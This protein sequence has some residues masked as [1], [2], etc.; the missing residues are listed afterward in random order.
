MINEYTDYSFPEL[1]EDEQTYL[2]THKY[3]HEVLKG[4]ITANKWI[5]LAAERHFKDL[6]RSE[7]NDFKYKFSP[8]RAQH[9]I[10]FFKLTTH[11][12]GVLAGQPIRLM[13]W[14]MF[15]IGSLFG[16]ITKEKDSEAKKFIK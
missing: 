5:K 3:C 13:P 14:Q 6:K 4:N 9:A 7:H 11:T 16:W 8:A 15:I 2:W 1:K 10:D 12:K